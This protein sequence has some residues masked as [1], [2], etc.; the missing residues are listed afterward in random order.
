[1]ERPRS[2]SRSSSLLTLTV[3]VVGLDGEHIPA[4]TVQ[5]TDRLSYLC[6][7][8][9]ERLGKPGHA[10]ELLYDGRKLPWTTTY[11][12]ESISDGASITT[13]ISYNKVCIAFS[14]NPNIN[15]EPFGSHRICLRPGKLQHVL[16]RQR[17]EGRADVRN[18]Q[19]RFVSPVRTVLPL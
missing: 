17:R 13:V 7:E 4:K 8:V 6:L 9:G 11:A 16:P 2:R 14:Q 1:M 19:V 10:V 3:H 18:M 12:L 15:P 5:A